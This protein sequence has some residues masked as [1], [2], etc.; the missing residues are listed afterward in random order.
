VEQE[1]LR[2]KACRIRETDRLTAGRG[3]ERGH[4]CC[5]VMQLEPG[6]ME[7]EPFE[8]SPES[9]VEF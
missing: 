5:A 3:R 9:Q 6:F 8:R 7:D 1:E 4:R 2:A